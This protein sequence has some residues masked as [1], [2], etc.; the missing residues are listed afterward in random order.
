MDHLVSKRKSLSGN[1][2]AWV[3]TNGKY[4]CVDLVQKRSQVPKTLKKM[5]DD[6]GIP[7]RLR[8]DQAL[9]LVGAHTE[10]QKEICRVRTKMS[11]TKPGA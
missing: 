4:T 8:A 7:E 9:E 1:T 2:G 10:F 6:V 11:F 3:Y 5:I